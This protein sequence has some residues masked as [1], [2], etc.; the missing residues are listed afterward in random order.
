MPTRDALLVTLLLAGVASASAAP[1]DWSSVQSVGGIA[2]SDPTPIERGWLLPVS[3]NVSGLTQVTTKP[4]AL[5]SSLVCL[6][7]AATIQGNGVFL[8][9]H[10][11]LSQNGVSQ[12]CPPAQLGRPKAGKYKVYY[13]VPNEEAHFLREVTVGL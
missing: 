4:T 1:L 13:R 6:R 11:S 10:T 3:A 5:N 12:R 9:V 8:T 2:V 7:T